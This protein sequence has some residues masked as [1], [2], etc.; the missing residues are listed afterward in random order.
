MWDCKTSKMSQSPLAALNAFGLFAARSVASDSLAKRV[1][2]S[3]EPSGV[4]DIARPSRHP[5]KGA[6]MTHTTALA[7]HRVAFRVLLAAFFIQGCNPDP[8]PSEPVELTLPELYVLAEQ[9]RTYAVLETD[10]HRIC[11]ASPDTALCELGRRVFSGQ[12]AGCHG[13][14][15]VYERK[16]PSLL[17]LLGRTRGFVS[18]YTVVADEAYLRRAIQHHSADLEYVPGWKGTTY[19]SPPKRNDPSVT[20]YARYR[21]QLESEYYQLDYEPGDPLDGLVA[22]VTALSPTP[23]PIG[24]VA[25]QLKGV[26]DDRARAIRREIEQ[27]LESVHHCYAVAMATSA[28]APVD[29]AH[30]EELLLRLEGSRDWRDVVAKRQNIEDES[31]LGCVADAMADVVAASP[32]SGLPSSDIE[33]ALTFLPDSTDRVG[34]GPWTP[35]IVPR[36]QPYERPKPVSDL[37]KPEDYLAVVEDLERRARWVHHACR[38]TQEPWRC[39]DAAVTFAIRCARCHGMRG[40]QL[41]K[42]PSLVGLLGRE[43]AFLSGESIVADEEYVTRSIRD[44]FSVDEYVPGW[45]GT[46]ERV[47]ATKSGSATWLDHVIRQEQSSWMLSRFGPLSLD[48]VRDLTSFVVALSPGTG[49]RVLG[50]VELELRNIKDPQAVTLLQKQLNWRR[51]SIQDC[52]AAEFAKES[53]VSGSKRLERTLRLNL[54]RLWDFQSSV[55]GQRVDNPMV[56]GCVTDAVADAAVAMSPSQREA[57]E[58]GEVRVTLHDDGGDHPTALLRRQ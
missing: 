12:C 48:D 26:D 7:R 11:A 27:Q 24:T 35:V 56:L 44:H 46:S 45:R 57:I 36:E 5:S 47:L 15:G 22:F 16:G 52:F 8:Q 42:G 31:L 33:V 14:Q 9:S 13:A 4:L 41:R 39:D 20:A 54:D 17:G 2:R 6:S 18:G 43:R 25:Y 28:A 51:D 21:K 40:V 50:R 19:L 55:R 58:A 53:R 34:V 32:R 38:R 10:Y 23:G 37:M 30:P 1:S 49:S 29:K 3:S